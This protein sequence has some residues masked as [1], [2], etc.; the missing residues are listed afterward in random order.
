MMINIQLAIISGAIV[1]FDC[2]S[3]Q[4]LK[5]IFANTNIVVLK[6]ALPCLIKLNTWLAS[7]WVSAVKLAIIKHFLILD[8]FG[9][10]GYIEV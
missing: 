10:R 8:G 5:L 6:K 9:G 3:I 4:F 1:Q 2:C 7:E